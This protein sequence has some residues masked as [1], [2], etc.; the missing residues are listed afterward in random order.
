MPGLFGIAGPS[1]PGTLQS[2]FDR[3]L[4]A[5]TGN[6]FRERLTDPLEQWAIGRTHLGALQPDAQL[7]TSEPVQVLLHGDLYNA[8]QLSTQFQ[9]PT[10]PA[11]ATAC[12]R[13][14]Y[15]RLDLDTAG[16]L[17]G[18]YCA[19]IVDTEKRR[20]LLMSDAVG[21]YPIYWTIADGLLVFGSELRAVLRHPAV[22]RRLDPGAVADYVT[23][24]YPFGS[25][26]LAEGVQMLPAG[27]TLVFEWET[28]RVEV[29]RY[30]DVA[31]AFQ[32]WEGNKS[33]YTEAV[34]EAFQGA[35][36]RALDG[37]HAFGLSL[38]GGLDSRAILSAVN[39]HG[40]SLASYTLG[41]HGCADEVIARR[42]ADIAGTRHTFFPLDQ[43]YLQ[44]FLPNLREM[45][46]LTDGMYLSHGLTEMLALNFL[47][48]ADFKVLLRGH[49]G[50]LAKAS[51]AWPLHTDDAIHGFT[52]T[53]QLI[54][55]LLSRGNYIS[56][57]VQPSALFTEAWAPQIEGAAR[58][59]LVGA[60]AGVPLAPA[61]LCSYLYLTEIHRRFTLAS[62]ELF[63]HAVE[64]R[65]PFID[66][67][68]LH[69]LFRGR[70]RWRDDTTL[71]R[72]ITAAGNQ[73]LL[74][75]RNSNTG[76][77]GDAGPLLEK[78]LDKANTL[79]KRLNVRGYRHYH[80]F[81]AWMREQLLSSVE[82]VLLSQQSL[83]RGVLRESGL[84]R[85]LDDTRHRRTDHSYLLQ[86]LLLVELWQQENL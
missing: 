30:L 20:V 22:K 63:R 1:Q 49:G 83:G 69:V 62:L 54:P 86:V 77:P 51:L 19:A 38:S 72:A 26:T 52:S 12:V 84:R 64:I 3:I 81:Q 78:A 37:D 21:S 5:A 41:V 25:K 53:D 15:R 79:F 58:R 14:S 36:R 74:K 61:D 24:G 44:N 42:L 60:V 43:H 73:K 35:V 18:A 57:S 47:R 6:L 75:V 8:R 17:E 10:T 13:A 27:S 34:T 4:P 68:F 56:G 65:L 76:A 40:G 33:D 45:V 67:A 31:D 28:G 48:A 29:R 46:V 70:A 2:S 7:H 23:F 11:N 66:L 71:H 39:G 55:Y 80:N 85:L 59:S 50:E 32:P 82:T 9:L 16:Q